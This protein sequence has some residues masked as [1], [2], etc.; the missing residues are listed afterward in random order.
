[1]KTNPFNHPKLGGDV[2]DMRKPMPQR[3]PHKAMSVDEIW[4]KAQESINKK[5]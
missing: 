1:M 5:K 4:K 2:V 3:K